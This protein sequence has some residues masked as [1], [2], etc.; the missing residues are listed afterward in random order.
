MMV[1]LLLLFGAIPVCASAQPIGT[2]LEMRMEVTA[3]PLSARPVERCEQAA[4]VVLGTKQKWWASFGEA[5]SGPD[6][7][8]AM[9]RAPLRCGPG[10]LVDAAASA[11]GAGASAAF[12]FEISV[13]FGRIEDGVQKMEVT[14]ASRRVSGFA[15][16]AEPSYEESTVKR[17]LTAEQT[18]DYFM[19]LAIVGAAER[20][21][22]DAGELFLHLRIVPRHDSGA[23]FGTV[24]VRSDSPGAEVLVDGGVVGRVPDSGVQ[25]LRNLPVGEQ[26]LKVRDAAGREASRRCW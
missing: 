24:M 11:H 2:P 20:S 26:E 5:Q 10:S 21:Q 22:L 18:E 13:Y 9:T 16:T 14:V 4:D 19:P 8:R 7:G 3:N 17:L 15:G 25:T 23:S 12:A 6:H 1:L